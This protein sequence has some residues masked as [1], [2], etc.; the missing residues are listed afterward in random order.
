MSPAY[1]G[2]RKY[3]KT[4]RMSATGDVQRHKTILP[5]SGLGSGR[6]RVP[7]RLKGKRAYHVY[8]ET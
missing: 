2:R 1:L 7:L 4:L 6:L 8:E 3:L 5:A